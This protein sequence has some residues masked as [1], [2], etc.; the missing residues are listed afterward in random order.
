MEKNKPRSSSLINWKFWLGLLISGIFLFLAVRNVDL[1]KTW[2][3]IRSANPVFLLYAVLFQMVHYIFR[4]LRWGVLLQPIRE[5]RFINRFNSTVIGFA[6]NCVLPARLGEFIRANYLGQSEN[7]SKSSAFGTV[8]VER[9]FDGFTLLL[10]LVIG[11][12]GTVFPEEWQKMALKLRS[13]GFVLFAG[14]ILVIS[15]LAA[16]KNKSDFFLT[17]LNKFLFF[18]SRKSRQ[19][20]LDIIQNFSQGLILLQTPTGWFKAVSFSILLW[21]IALCQVQLVEY[22]LGISLSFIAAFIIL[23]MGSLGVIIPSSPG[24]IGTYH[25]AVQYGFIFYNIHKEEALSAAII[26]HATFFFPT[27]LFGLISF[28][29]MQGNFKKAK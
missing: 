12:M 7:V 26:L 3:V 2:H 16:F 1:I 21:F 15:M 22:S 5:T 9:F 20:I 27:I 19:K 17:Q 8:V 29:S 25:L 18:L 6:A 4:A 11:L 14:Y 10:I 28:L 24:F 13:T 23:A